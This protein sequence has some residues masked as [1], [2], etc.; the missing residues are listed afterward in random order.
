MYDNTLKISGADHDE[1][2]DF[3]VW[4]QS[5]ILAITYNHLKTKEQLFY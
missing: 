4:K 1:R 2:R 5:K 3:F